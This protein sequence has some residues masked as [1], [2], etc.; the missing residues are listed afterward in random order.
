METPVRY[1]DD[2][3]LRRTVVAICGRKG[4]GKDT[5]AAALVDAGFKHE[6]F[7][8]PLKAA[9]RE[10][11]GLTEAQVEGADKDVYDARWKR[12][13]REILQFVG[14]EV[15]QYRIQDLLPGVRRGFWATSLVN[16]ICAG[17]DDV[18]ISDMR[19]PH[20]LEA[21]RS[22]LADCIVVP[23]KVVRPAL[24][25]GDTHPSETEMDGIDCDTIVNDGRVDELR[26]KVLDACRAQRMC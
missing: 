4:A 8:A 9:C 12:T 14:T 6:K 17:T 1:A 11:F 2:A 20:E 13:P 15:F 7:A 24:S 16:R 5:A 19:F 22:S 10:L 25:D 26:R 18:V 3:M 23:V 21:L